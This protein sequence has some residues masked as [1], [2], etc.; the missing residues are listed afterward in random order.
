ME[1]EIN[2]IDVIKLFCEEYDYAVKSKYVVKPISLA[3]YRTWKAI[4]EIEPSRDLSKM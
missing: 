2:I 1:K 4:N 3:L